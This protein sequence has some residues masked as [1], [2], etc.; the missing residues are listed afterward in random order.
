MDISKKMAFSP[1]V[2]QQMMQQLSIIDSFKGNW[3]AIELQHSKHLK[4]LKKIATIESIGS[5]TRIEGATLTNAEVE[6]LLKSVKITKPKTRDEEEVV[7]YYDVLQIILDN[8]ETIKLTENYL[9]Q[10]HSILLKHSG[11][12]Q[13][14]KGSYKNLSNKVV[15][16]YPDGTQRT[17]FKTTEPHLTPAEMQ[18]LITWAKERFTKADT[19]PLV[20]IA[21][22]IYEFLSIHPYQD[23]NGRLSR[24]LTTL[25]MMQQD[26]KFIQYVSFENIIETRKDDYYRALMDG[27]KNR[28]KTEERIDKWILFFMECM[29]ILTKR[30][31]AKYATYSQLEKG[32]N[33]RQKKIIQLLKKNKKAQIKDIDKAFPDYSRNTLKKDIAYLVNEGLI[34]KTGEGRG[35]TYH[36]KQ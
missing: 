36:P 7:G 29:V 20:I 2:Y 11:K 18:I 3:Q 17:I 24:L 6:K 4:E 31:E 25:L 26:Y 16:N 23:G 21:V 19:H 5:S 30:L 1:A 15:A 28:G 32:L 8:Y 27:Q 12:D 9:H 22:F 13:R 10:L 14:H 34:I 35:V 33:E